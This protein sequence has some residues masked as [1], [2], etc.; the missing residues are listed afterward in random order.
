MKQDSSSIDCER[1]LCPAGHAVRPSGPGREE[2]ER[3]WAGCPP[4]ECQ[5]CGCVDLN[6]TYYGCNYAW[7]TKCC[8]MSVPISTT[9]CWAAVKIVH[10]KAGNAQTW[11][12]LATMTSLLEAAPIGATREVKLPKLTHAEALALRALSRSA[13]DVARTIESLQAWAAAAC[14]LCPRQD[15]ALGSPGR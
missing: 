1:E 11:D 6:L 9:A 5:F 10:E 3:A 13:C 15:Q 12:P 2:G 7:C 4:T 8:R 14:D